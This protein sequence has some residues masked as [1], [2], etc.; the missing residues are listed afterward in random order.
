MKK[1]KIVNYIM[2]VLVILTVWLPYTRIFLLDVNFGNIFVTLLSLALCINSF[3]SYKRE[4]NKIDLLLFIIGLSPLIF[5]LMIIFLI[6][7]EV[8]PVA[9]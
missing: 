8:I 7:I 4:K 9:P 1:F 2:A 6:S 3:I 5:I